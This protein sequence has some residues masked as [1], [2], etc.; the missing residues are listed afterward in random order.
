[1]D[2]TP[3]EARPVYDVV[4][5]RIEE[6]MPID[7]DQD[8]PQGQELELLVDLAMFYE[9]GIFRTEHQ[10]KCERALRLNPVHWFLPHKRK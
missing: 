9:R 1:M 7:P 2:I 6:L 5:A 4:M 8:S 10:I 3:P